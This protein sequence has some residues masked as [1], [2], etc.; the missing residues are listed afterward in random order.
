[1]PPRFDGDPYEEIL[2]RIISLCT[3]IDYAIKGREEYE[4]LIRANKVHYAQYNHAIRGTCPNF[5]AI[6][7]TTSKSKKSS[8]MQIPVMLP[9]DEDA[10]MQNEVIYLEQVRRTIAEYVLPFLLGRNSHWI[11][12]CRKITWHL[13][14]H[15][16]YE[17]I[18]KYIKDA[19]S[20]W[21]VPTEDCM[22]SVIKTTRDYVG[23]LVHKRF[24]QFK[25][26]EDFLAC[27]LISPRSLFAFKSSS[28]YLQRLHRKDL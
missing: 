6:S 16:P 17:V 18:L 7:F 3:E 1:V 14:G 23:N 15:T 9:E 25:M 19:T 22:E 8:G 24:N 4:D 20:N 13:P 5:Q 26:L 21:K 11:L 10:G 28:R 2:R 12:L 27:V